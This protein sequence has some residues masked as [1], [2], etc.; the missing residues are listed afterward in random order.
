MKNT[1]QHKYVRVSLVSGCHP[2]LSP[3]LIV[4]GLYFTYIQSHVTP[5]NTVTVSE[6]Q[7]YKRFSE[8]LSLLPDVMTIRGSRDPVSVHLVQ[9]SNKNDKAIGNKK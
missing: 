7:I 9:S 3:R 6:V 8:R 5:R 4:S 1:N 2:D